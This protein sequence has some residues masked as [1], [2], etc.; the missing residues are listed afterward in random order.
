MNSY[1]LYNSYIIYRAKQSIARIIKG[2]MRTFYSLWISTP[3]GAPN[4]EGIRASGLC[5]LHNY[6][7]PPSLILPYIK[8]W[9]E[10]SPAVIIILGPR[11]ANS[12][13]KPASLARIERRCGIEPVGP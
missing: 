11:P 13:R 4:A 6:M 7:Y 2:W 8:N 10:T 1:E 12:P 5:E 9:P 3:G